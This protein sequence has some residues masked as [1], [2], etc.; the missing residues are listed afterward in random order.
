MMKLYSPTDVAKITGVSKP[1]IR[2]YTL[3]Y[4]AYFSGSATPGPGQSRQ[5]TPDDIKLVSFIISRSNAGYT[6]ND[7]LKAL[8]TGELENYAFTLSE[9]IQ[10]ATDGPSDDT[11]T[12]TALVPLETFYQ[13]LAQAQTAQAQLQDYKQREA[14]AVESERA[15]QTRI[16][17]LERELGSVAG[18]LRAIKA[19]RRR[20]AWW[21]A[22]FGGE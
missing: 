5:Y 17:E 7:T 9:P 6:H 21:V 10:D 13:A 3:T 14:A 4:N 18:E 20:P 1:A 19:Q 22:I 8:E 12:S 2:S 11:G 15:A 16:N